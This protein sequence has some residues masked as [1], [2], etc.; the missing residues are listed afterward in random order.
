[1]SESGSVGS[2]GSNSVRTLAS[3]AS[4]TVKSQN[5]HNENGSVD[6]SSV[7]PEQR[8]F[9]QD[10]L[11]PGDSDPFGGPEAA[12]LDPPADILYGEVL[13]ADNPVRFNL[14]MKVGADNFIAP[15]HNGSISPRAVVESEQTEVQRQAVL[16][17]NRYLGHH[18]ELSPLVQHIFMEVMRHKPEDPLDF[19]CSHVF[20]DGKERDAMVEIRKITKDRVKYG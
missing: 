1:M 10:D 13:E 5:D 19:I 11:T 6:G 3:T 9:T 16:A 20:K 7:A 17:R 15:S 12:I 4:K 8:E 18:P 14:D 2:I